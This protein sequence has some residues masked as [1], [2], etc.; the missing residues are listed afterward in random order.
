MGNEDKRLA[1]LVLRESLQKIL[2]RLQVERACSLVE[3]KNASA[4][5]KGT[6][7][8]YSLSLTLAQSAALFGASGVE[9][10]LQFVHKVGAGISCIA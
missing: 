6:R 2:L 9:S 3:Q 10:V 1:V 5:Q 7:D 8:G 4:T